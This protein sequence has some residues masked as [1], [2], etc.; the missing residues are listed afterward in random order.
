MSSKG[1]LLG[2]IFRLQV[3][4]TQGGTEYSTYT[5]RLQGISKSTASWQRGVSQ[6]EITAARR[7]SSIR[8]KLEHPITT[9]ITITNN[10]KIAPPCDIHFS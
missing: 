7:N 2:N 5:W 3:L 9:A 6:R 8:T 4:F 1:N 10:F